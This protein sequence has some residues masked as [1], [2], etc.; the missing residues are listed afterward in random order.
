MLTQSSL[1][2]DVLTAGLVPCLTL[3]VQTFTWGGV[4]ERERERERG[5]G[6]REGDALN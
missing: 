6:D 2:R 1:D 5:G 3:G 4:S